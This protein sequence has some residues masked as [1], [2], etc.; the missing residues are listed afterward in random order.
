M[1][2]SAVWRASAC[3]LLA[4]FSLLA[5]SRVTTKIADIQEN[6][7]QYE[8]RQ[9]WV[10]GTVTSSAKLPFMDE[11]FYTLAD[12]TGEITVVTQ[13]ALPPQG[14]KR[15][16]RGTVQSQFKLFGKSAAIVIREDG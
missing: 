14:S 11:S 10:H 16:V 6:P 8:N 7:G 15:I 3:L 13:G 12:S 5:C 4:G 9:V 1:G 2:A